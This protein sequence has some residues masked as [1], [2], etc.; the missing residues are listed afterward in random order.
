MEEDEESRSRKLVKEFLAS[1]KKSE[2]S[3]KNKERRESKR[4]EAGYPSKRPKCFVKLD[5]VKVKLTINMKKGSG[6]QTEAESSNFGPPVT[7]PDLSQDNIDDLAGCELPIDTPSESRASYQTSQTEWKSRMEGQDLKW[8][9]TRDYIHVESMKSF[10]INKASICALCQNQAS[11]RCQTCRY[12]LCPTCD[13][14]IH[15][16]QVTHQRKCEVNN[17][18]HLLQCTEFLTNEGNLITLNIPLPMFIP[19]Q[20]DNCLGIS[21]ILAVAGKSRTALIN[22]LGRFDCFCTVF[23]R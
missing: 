15:S 16:K 9:E 18:L 19:E 5:G 22:H 3:R 2:N 6:Y 1:L 14:S 13:I 12:H 4:K 20:C 17:C 23:C 8:K 11:V 10:S 7:V 21:C